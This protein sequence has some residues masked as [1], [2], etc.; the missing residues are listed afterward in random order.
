ML[1]KEF[2]DRMKTLM[3]DD[4]EKLFF[5]MENG[6]A[7]KA[8]RING[9]KTAA[10]LFESSKA[11]IDKEPMQGI[12]NAYYTKERFPGSLPE[13][14]SGAVYMQDPSAMATVCALDICEGWRV[15][16]S[17]AAPGGKT[18][19]LAAAVGD[20][21]VVV[22]NE[23]DAA[24]ARVLQSNVERMGCK[25]TVILNVDTKVLSQTYPEEFDLVLCDAPCSGEGMFRKNELAIEEWSIDN[26]IMCAERQREILANVIQCVKR[27]G[28]LL[29]STCTF[30]IEENEQ[31]VAW[32]LDNYPEFE[33]LEVSDAVR[34][35]TSDAIQLEGCEHDMSKARRFYPHISRGEGQFIALFGKKPDTADLPC[36]AANDG[37][38]A[39]SKSER[40]HLKTV[41]NDKNNNRRLQNKQNVELIELGKAFI[42]DN[43]RGELV[44]N[45]A[46]YF[47]KLWLVP[48]VSL[49]EYGII[50]PGVCVG[51]AQKGR[52]V[53]HHQLFSAYGANFKRKLLM[54]NSMPSAKAYLFGEE[55]ILRGIKTK[56]LKCEAWCPEEYQDE[57]NCEVQGEL[58]LAPQN[59]PNGWAA[60][61]IGNCACGGA[62][63][64]GACVSD[65]ELSD[66]VAKNHYPKGLRNKRMG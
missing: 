45:P 20:R 61:I 13:H 53:P 66:G 5:E 25:N 46:V 26:V 10:D 56:A 12:K 50:A 22:A 48:D 6:E 14:H 64:S 43:L 55:L 57:Q 59:A 34:R 17:C 7:V 2:K 39:I 8:F 19:Q 49:A 1:P 65:G 4:A 16:D 15:L 27:G 38:A 58:Y 23:Y 24:R 21:G 30:A 11:S 9:I 40:K 41:K 62:K 35:I 3:G 31:N 32:L 60:V 42:R 52:F 18:T 29:Y 37:D 44:G 33:L 36:L 63:I 28:R 51:E 47:N 54:G